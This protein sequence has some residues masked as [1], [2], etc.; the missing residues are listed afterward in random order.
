PQD[1]PHARADGAHVHAASGRR[2]DR[3]KGH[4]MHRRSFLTLLGASAAAWPL[5]ARAQQRSMPVVGWLNSGQQLS[6][7][8]VPAM[9]RKG[10][11][12][13]GYVEGRNVAFELSSTPQI[14]QLPALAAE[15]VQRKVAV[16]V[17]WG[18]ANTARVAKAATA[19]LP[20]VFANGGDP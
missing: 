10:L 15:L 1:R 18:S 14:D 11:A 17:A 9:V 6:A 2:G 3:M 4:R 16:I 19:T 12:E 5:A 20:I 8:S 13:M 7:A